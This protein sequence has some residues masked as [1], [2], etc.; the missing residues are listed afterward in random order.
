MLPPLADQAKSCARSPEIHEYLVARVRPHDDNVQAIRAF[1]DRM[2]TASQVDS[3]LLPI[4]DGL[5]LLRQR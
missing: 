1:S 5:T 2:A 3:V 4:S